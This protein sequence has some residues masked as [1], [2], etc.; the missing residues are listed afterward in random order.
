MRVLGSL[1][2]LEFT[3]SCGVERFC[4]SDYFRSLHLGNVILTPAGELGLIDFSDLRIYRR[5]LPAFMRRR[6]IRRMLGITGE[7]DWIDSEAILKARS[8]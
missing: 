3:H 6:N 1:F 8:A 4:R 2:G 5:P 7:R